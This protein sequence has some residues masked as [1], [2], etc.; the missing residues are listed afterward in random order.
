MSLGSEQHTWRNGHRAK[1]GDALAIGVALAIATAAPLARAQDAGSQVHL[2]QLSAEQTFGI[3]SQPLTTALTQFGQQSGMQVT[4]HGTLPRDLTAPAVRGTMTGEEALNRLLAGSGLTYTMAGSTVAIEKP[5]QGADGAIV[6]DPVTVEGRAGPPRQAQIGNLPPE[7]PGGQVARGGQLG[8]LGNKDMMDTPFN[9]TNYTSKLI[10]DQQAKTLGDV[11]ANDPSV[12]KDFDT[13]TGIDNW[14]IRGLGN[15]QGVAFGGLYGV[16][17]AFGNTMASESIERVEVLKGATA[18]LTGLKPTQGAELGLINVVPKRAG[19]E[20]LT[21]FT[22]DYAMDSQFGGHIDVG[23]RFGRDNALGVRFNGV[24][25]NGDTPIDN[26][27]R[28]TRLAAL[29][30]D[31]RGDAVRVSADLGYQYQYLNAPRR[32]VS[33]ADGVPVPDEPDNNSNY[34]DP[35]TF[36]ENSNY[37]GALKGEWDVQEQLTA[38]ASV[39]GS[40]HDNRNQVLNR[41]LQDTAGTLTGNPFASVGRRQDTTGEAGFRGHGATGP[42]HHDLVLSGAWSRQDF[43]FQVGNAVTLPASN[44]FNPI[45]F[46]EPDFGNLPDPEDVPKSSTSENTGLAFADTLSVLDERIQLML[47]LRWQSVSQTN[48][49]I[50]TGAVTA[51]YGEEAITPAVALVVKPWQNVSLYGNYIQALERGPTA[52]T[53][54]SNAGEAFPPIKTEQY[55]VGAKVDTGRL[56]ATLAAFTTTR[57]NGFTD[58][59]TNTF[60]LNG[61]TLYRGIELTA[62]GEVTSGVRFIGGVTYLDARLQKTNGGLNEGNKENGL[63]EYRATLTG[64]W[65]TPFVQ[66]LTLSATG[67][68]QSS[69]FEDDGNTQ[70]VDGWYRFDL[71]ARYTIERPG[72]EPITVRATVRNVMDSDYWATSRDRLGLSEPRTFL[73]SSTFR[74]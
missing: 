69:T 2:A 71:G 14:T 41:T 18:L 73:L 52:P 34:F 4:V 17:P 42:V 33:I 46:G 55:E 8:I 56:A 3:P 36:S 12:V 23:R 13:G 37:Y 20:P 50:T 24:Y 57:P 67:Q 74:F 54:A 28:E 32:P 65:D 66:G 49:N 11:I 43:G 70:E 61:E 10:E 48:F 60:E 1:L 72:W 59:A 16:A 68:W 19:D 22:P 38:F 9:Q 39:G 26:Q 58:A 53:T 30:V 45:F 40:I 21:E 64:E 15:N 62:F 25:R 63:P 44:L 35:W 47:G 7:Y 5:G 51:E 6:L 31:Y 29:G 27:S